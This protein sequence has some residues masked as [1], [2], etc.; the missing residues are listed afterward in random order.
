MGRDILAV[1]AGFTVW[2]ACWLAYNAA[3]RE[4]GL[5]PQ[6]DTS[7]IGSVTPLLVLLIGSSLF[8]LAAGYVA[9]W[10]SDSSGYVVALILGAVLVGVGAF[11]QSRVWKLMPVWYHLSFL[12]LLVPATLAGAWMHLG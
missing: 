9:A 8:S 3:L 1:V 5:L 6:E 12:L 10:V 2:T 11:V 7:P 4:F